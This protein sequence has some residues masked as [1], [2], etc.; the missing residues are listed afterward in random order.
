MHTN[1]FRYRLHATFVMLVCLGTMLAC[2]ISVNPDRGEKPEDLAST[3]AVLQ[4]TQV[5]IQVQ[6]QQQAQQQNQQQGQPQVQPQE[7]QP[8]LPAPTPDVI[9]EGISFSFDPGIANRVEP[10]KVPAMQNQEGPPG[11]NYPEHF[12]F[13]FPGY[14]LQER[15]H[16]PGIYIYPVAAYQALDQIASERVSALKTILASKPADSTDALPFMPIWP[17]AQMIH[18]RLTYFDFQNG[19]GFRFLTQY[20]QAATPINNLEIFYTYQGITYDGA[21]YV[22][23]VLPVGHPSL[24]ANGSTVPN[25]DWATFSENYELHTAQTKQMLDAQPDNSFVPSLVLLDEIFRSLRVK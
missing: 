24:P 13:T 8:T 14:I 22:A 7:Q 17:A 21:Y 20:G 23:A 19:T 10:S 3:Q 11:G 5:A 9:F 1:N 12:L 2:G 6:Q 4:A 15:F 25:D 16:Q 18:A